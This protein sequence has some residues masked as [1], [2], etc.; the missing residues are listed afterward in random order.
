MTSHKQIRY[1]ESEI[2]TE[3]TINFLRDPKS[4]LYSR[5]IIVSR[6]D[7]GTGKVIEEEG[8]PTEDLYECVDSNATD[9]D[10]QF[11]IQEIDGSDRILKFKKIERED[12]ESGVL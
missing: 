5:I 7:L 1:V 9:F 4:G 12:G 6:R 8:K 2:V 3:K 11:V 10:Q